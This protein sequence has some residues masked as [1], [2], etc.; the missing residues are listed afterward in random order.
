[1]IKN[2]FPKTNNRIFFSLMCLLLSFFITSCAEFQNIFAKSGNSRAR[3]HGQSLSEN[4]IDYT[5]R[6]PIRTKQGT[7]YFVQPGDTLAKIS[8]QFRHLKWDAIAQI[9][10]L[11]S[12]ELVVGRRLFIPHKKNLS[13]YLNISKVIQEDVSRAVNNR[14]LSF[15]WPIEEGRVTSVFGHRRGRPHDGIDI[16]AKIGTPIQAIEAGRVIYSDRYTSYGNLIVI[17]HP[18]NYYSAYAH[19]GK[20]YVK[21]GQHVRKGQK[22]SLVGMTGR[23]T[24][25]HLHFEMRVKTQAIDPLTVLPDKR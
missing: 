15:V 23:T 10:N 24:G 5:I 25:P 13:D 19:N 11:Y 20:V 16:G 22:I 8:K 14:K 2:S 6:K 9:N 17:K 12:S 18:K 7:Y 4:E 21:Q 3:S 1:M